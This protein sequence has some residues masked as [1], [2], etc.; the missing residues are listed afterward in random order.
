MVV[1]IYLCLF[2][3]S[4]IVRICFCHLLYIKVVSICFVIYERNPAKTACDG[5]G[6]IRM[7]TGLVVISIYSCHLR[8]LVIVKYFFRQTSSVNRF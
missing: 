5:V 4:K 7:Y 1:G 2:L 6:S 8:D 3:N